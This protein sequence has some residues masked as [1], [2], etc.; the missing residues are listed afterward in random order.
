MTLHYDAHAV[1]KCLFE[2]QATVCRRKRTLCFMSGQVSGRSKRSFLAA[3]IEAMGV[4]N[5]SF[6]QY[7]D[8]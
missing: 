4:T 8:A 3:K 5:D 1:S 6:K 7:G 2:T